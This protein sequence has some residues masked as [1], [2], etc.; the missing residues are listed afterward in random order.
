MAPPCEKPA[1]TIDDAS[2]LLP[3]DQRLDRLL[4][5]ANAIGIFPPLAMVVADVVPGAHHVAAVDRHRSLGRVGKHEPDAGARRQVKLR[6]DVDE[7]VTVGAEPVHPD[8]AGGGRG[9]GL[10]L[11]RFEQRRH[12]GRSAG[13]GPGRS[14]GMGY[15]S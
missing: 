12:D 7:I 9:R 1:S 11:D 10:D 13:D 3:L 2:R 8:D 6:H 5:R 14:P 4:G 15:S